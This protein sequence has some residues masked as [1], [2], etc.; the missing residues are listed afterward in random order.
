[1]PFNFPV[2]RRA[3]RSYC[4]R[5]KRISFLLLIAALCCASPTLAQDAATDEKLNKL[6][7]HVEDLL[8]AKAEQDKRI[9][10]L[11]KEVESLRE[12]AG[13]PTGDYAT[14]EDL[15][16]L[17]E[18][19]AEKLQEIDDKRV[20]DSKR[21]ADAIEKLAK[22]P[23]GG[24]LKTPKAPKTPVEDSGKSSGA[25]GGGPEKGFE[26][27]IVSGDSLSIIAQKCRE[28]GVK[29]TTEQI[30]KANPGLKERNLQVGQKIFIPGS[31]P[32]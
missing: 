1:M 30:Q 4:R 24:G 17:A 12:Q 5:M 3:A 23:A 8:A 15:R 20:A 2:E 21:I 26:Y 19:F 10:A 22:A 11:V 28:Q 9:A 18:K 25:A 16:K 29:V 32:K 14:R 27:V 7:G 6:S 31:A 13:K